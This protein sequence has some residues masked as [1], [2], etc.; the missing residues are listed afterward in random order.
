[1]GAYTLNIYKQGKV[2]LDI[3]LNNYCNLNYSACM[4]GTNTNKIPKSKYEF[5]Q[6]KKLCS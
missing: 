1:M 5:E 3:I 6:Y 4:F 2:K